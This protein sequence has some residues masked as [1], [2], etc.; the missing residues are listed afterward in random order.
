MNDPSGLP[1]YYATEAPSC[2]GVAVSLINFSPSLTLNPTAHQT[3]MS[4]FKW[5]RMYRSDG[6]DVRLNSWTTL[7]SHPH[8]TVTCCWFCVAGRGGG[9][10]EGM[11]REVKPRNGPL[12]EFWVERLR[13]K[14]RGGIRELPYNICRLFCLGLVE[15]SYAVTCW[16][17]PDQLLGVPALCFLSP[18]LPPPTT[19][20]SGEP[21]VKCGD[22]YW[23]NLTSLFPVLRSLV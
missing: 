14:S 11:G 13:D 22:N 21:V 10:E 16:G 17:F 2:Y 5:R 23:W 9:R 1:P 20:R 19:L 8:G 6:T 4:D 3:G 7:P 18:P 15:V 12:S